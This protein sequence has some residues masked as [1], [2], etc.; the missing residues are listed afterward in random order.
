MDNSRSSN[1]FVLALNEEN[2]KMI[3][4]RI[5]G[6]YGYCAK[7]TL[8]KELLSEISKVADSGFDI[9]NENTGKMIIILQEL[10]TKK[11]EILSARENEVLREI[12]LGKKYKQIAKK[13]Y[14]SVNTIHFHMKNIFQKLNVHSRHEA[15]TIAY[16][17]GLI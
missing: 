15:I 11:Q 4:N 8:P 1:V 9:N 3:N 14:V 16:R 12:A 10:E 5:S 7:I 6:A 2:E 17:I 13:L